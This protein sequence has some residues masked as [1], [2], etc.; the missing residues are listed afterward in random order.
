[1]TFHTLLLRT[2]RWVIAEK[3]KRLL[4]ALKHYEIVTE[5]FA[6]CVVIVVWV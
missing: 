2:L 5:I 1:M 4:S 6:I 3:G